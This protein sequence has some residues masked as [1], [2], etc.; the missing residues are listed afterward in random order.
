[1]EAGT[2][3]LEDALARYQRGTQLLRYCQT[4]LADAEQRVKMLEGEGLSDFRPEDLRDSEE[5]EGA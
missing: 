2:L 3:A 5:G 4:T 1:M